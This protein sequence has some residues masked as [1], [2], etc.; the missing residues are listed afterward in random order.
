M[1][2]TEEAL[3]KWKKKEKDILLSMPFLNGRK[4]KLSKAEKNNTLHDHVLN[5]NGM[6]LLCP[7]CRQLTEVKDNDGILTVYCANPTCDGKMS[8]K[9][10]HY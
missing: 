5:N 3:K 4:E 6:N 10:S 9:I 2:A 7:I 8:Q 1:G